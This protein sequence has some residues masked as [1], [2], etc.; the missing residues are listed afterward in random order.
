[1]NLLENTDSRVLM[2]RVPDCQA[3]EM[4]NYFNHVVVA[5]KKAL[6]RGNDSVPPQSYLLSVPVS[7]DNDL[8]NLDMCIMQ[9][10]CYLL[11]KGKIR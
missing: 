11:W 3:K 6:V 5:P 2:S 8:S 7:V 9:G 4:F 10:L 1:M